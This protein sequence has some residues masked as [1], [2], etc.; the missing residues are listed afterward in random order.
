MLS[1][2]RARTMAA[3]FSAIYELHCCEDHTFD[4]DRRLLSPSGHYRLFPPWHHD[5]RLREQSKPLH[6]T[7]RTSCPL[8][9]VGNVHASIFHRHRSAIRL[10]L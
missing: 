7:T 1:D 9:R 2:R 10:S 5:N 3:F 4:S 6:P 8:A